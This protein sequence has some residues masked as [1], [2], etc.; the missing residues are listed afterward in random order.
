MMAEVLGVAGTRA[1]IRWNGIGFVS[2]PGYG[3]GLIMNSY[4]FFFQMQ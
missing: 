3:L 2:P 4:S 1:A